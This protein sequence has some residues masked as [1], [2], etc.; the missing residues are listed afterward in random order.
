MIHIWFGSSKIGILCSSIWYK[1]DIRFVGCWVYIDVVVMGDDVEVIDRDDWREE[2]EVL[3]G[4][5]NMLVMVSDVFVFFLIKIWNSFWVD[6]WNKL[7]RD[8]KC[9]GVNTLSSWA[10]LGKNIF[11]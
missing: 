3:L 8:C 11:W 1:E 5:G 2:E 7:D 6:E 9:M 4:G 10:K